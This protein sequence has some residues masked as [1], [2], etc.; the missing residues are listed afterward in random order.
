[1]TD[2]YTHEQFKADHF[3]L[4]AEACQLLT[5]GVYLDGY[6]PSVGKP[7]YDRALQLMIDAGE[8]PPNGQH[9][10]FRAPSERSGE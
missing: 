5:S 8:L 7:N 2:E 6:Q 1:M 9:E 10:R 4:L 3:H